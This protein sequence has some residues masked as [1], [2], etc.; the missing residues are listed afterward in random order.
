MLADPDWVHKV[1]AS[2]ANQ[3]RRCISC[4]NCIDSMNRQTL[5][6]AVNPF[7]GR[8]SELSLVKTETP[9]Q[10]VVIGAGPGGLEAARVAALRGH[11][12]T[13][14]EREHRLGGALLLAA[15]VHD[16]NRFFLD[17]LK[18]AVRQLPVLVCLGIQADVEQVHALKPD[19][20]IV[21][22]GAEVVVPHNIQLQDGVWFGRDVRALLTGRWQ[23]WVQYWPVWAAPVMLKV[24]DVWNR[25]LNPRVMQLA[26]HV[27]MPFG[28]RVAIIGNDLPAVE[29]AEF[30]AKRRR[31]VYL[32]TAEGKLLPEVGRKRRAE[33]MDKLDLLNV[34]VNT[35][36]NFQEI[37]AKIVNYSPIGSEQRFSLEVDSVI[38]AGDAAADLTLADQ[39]QAAS[40]NIMT[41]GDCSGYG[42]IV[43]AVRQG[44]EVACSL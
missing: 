33:H 12:V 23:R 14:L 3:I 35:G 17:Y 28:K 29:I 22:T 26:A 37:S 16:D 42:Q 21:A 39:L 19:V 32:M 13:L 36:L 11:R 27:W 18:Q 40:L 8:E 2:S 7:T 41:V 4:E 5:A 34:R 43:K 6:C 20:V 44:A 10:V 31:T 30:L 9:K 25:F 24:G 1:Q 38:V 15:A